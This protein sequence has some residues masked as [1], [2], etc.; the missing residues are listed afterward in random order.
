M[1]RAPEALVIEIVGGQDFGTNARVTLHMPAGSHCPDHT[2]QVPPPA[3]L[4]H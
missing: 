4:S 1:A 2:T 3:Q